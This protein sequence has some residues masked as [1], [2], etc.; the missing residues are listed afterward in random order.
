M[1]RSDRRK[2]SDNVYNTAAD[3]ITPTHNHIVDINLSVI[4]RPCVVYA[5][6]KIDHRRLTVLAAYVTDFS[7]R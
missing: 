6:P 5:L 4:C 7:R 2:L 3:S 1:L